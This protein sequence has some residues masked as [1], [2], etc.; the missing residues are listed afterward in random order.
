MEFGEEVMQLENSGW[1]GGIDGVSG[2]EDWYHFMLLN[3]KN[4]R[5]HV[6]HGVI[7]ATCPCMVCHTDLYLS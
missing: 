3:L 4:G 1:L 2:E 7:G 5:S 6:G